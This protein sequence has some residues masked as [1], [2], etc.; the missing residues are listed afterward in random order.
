MKVP[1]ST[2]FVLCTPMSNSE[3]ASAFLQ[4]PQ[5][6]IIKTYVYRYFPAQAVEARWV[7]R[8]G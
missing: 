5:N 1:G 7:A 4:M 2:G 8:G 6:K 3:T